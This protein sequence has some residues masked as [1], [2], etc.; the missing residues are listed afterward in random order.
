M[1]PSHHPT[2]QTSGSR[3]AGGVSPSR[4]D[5]VYLQGPGSAVA[6]WGQQG[7]WVCLGGD[8]VGHTLG[9]KSRRTSGLFNSP[10]PPDLAPW[11]HAQICSFYSQTHACPLPASTA[12]A[13][14]QAGTR[15]CPSLLGSASSLLSHLCSHLLHTLSTWQPELSKPRLNHGV[16]SHTVLQ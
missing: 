15:S 4:R 2:I 1:G 11:V 10:P 12:A 9:D 14:G 5:D 8:T 6:P 7:L 16:R 13:L 3:E